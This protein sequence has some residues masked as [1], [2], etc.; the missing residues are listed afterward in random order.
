MHRCLAVLAFIAALAGIA[1]ADEFDAPPAVGLWSLNAS[2]DVDDEGGYIVAGSV[3][4]LPNE[5][6]FFS[7]DIGNSDSSTD[8]ADFESSFASLLADYSFGPVGVSASAGWYSDDTIADRFRYGGSIYV[9]GG[10][11]RVGVTAEDWHSDFDT[12][13]FDGILDSALPISTTADCDLDNT[14]LGAR[15]SYSGDKFGAYLSYRNYDYSSPDCSFGVFVNNRRI[16]D[17]SVLV[18]AAPQLFR[19][20]AAA[21]LGA[22]RLQLVSADSAFLDESISAGVSWRHKNS[23]FGIDY[24]RS[25]DLFQQLEGDTI[26]GRV[27][28]PVGRAADLEL[29]LGVA[30]GDQV[31]SIGF[32]GVSIFWYLAAGP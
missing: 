28:F 9:K 26:T 17:V 31:D 25:E 24:Y 8:F 27:L 20:L 6:A 13:Q 7:A 3:A 30:D 32:M 12:F 5:R 10:G 29:R 1:C 23:L 16:E 18:D 2:L 21:T 11:F 4:Y 19:A 14:T 22:T 15:A